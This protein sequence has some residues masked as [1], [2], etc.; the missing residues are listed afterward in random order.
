MPAQQNETLNVE[1]VELAMDIFNEE[2][3]ELW[4]SR[5]YFENW[6]YPTHPIITN[7]AKNAIQSIPEQQ[8][9]KSVLVRKEK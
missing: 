7:L 9:E 2:Y 3:I 5:N 6:P 1:V 8:V 4:F